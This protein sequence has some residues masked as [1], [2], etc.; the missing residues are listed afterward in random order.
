M[1]PTADGAELRRVHLVHQSFGDYVSGLVGGL[2]DIGLE[3]TVTTVLSGQARLSAP[4]LPGSVTHRT[5]TL[6][7]F[8]D[9]RS[10][11]RAMAE[12]RRA[13]AVPTDVVHWQAVGNPWVDAAFLVQSSRRPVVVTV[14][15]MQPHPG[16]GTVLPGTFAAMQRVAA[17]ADRVTVHAP[18]VR[19]QGVAIG[20]DRDRIS[21]I[22]HGE[23]ASIYRP[24]DELPFSPSTEPSVLFFGRVQG[25]KGLDVL[26]EAMALLDAEGAQARLIVAGSG[27]TLDRLLPEG[28]PTPDWCTV[29]RGHIPR[30]DVP[31]LFERAAVVALPYHEASQSGVA[32]LA[33]GFGRPVVATRTPGLADIV[34]EGRTGL[35]IPTGDAPALADAIGRITADP[36]LAATLCRGAWD[37]ARGE[38][39]WSTIAGR[40][41]DVYRQAAD[42]HRNGG[43]PGLLARTLTAGRRS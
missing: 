11:L 30:K 33:A 15:D 34:E 6:P 35:L 24:V 39:S 2:V 41:L 7:R 5:V 40:L 22:H 9:P 3:V 42:D 10:P 12:I 19:D 25:Y 16:D 36:D 28:R 23:L 18:H 4:S 20:I 38:L 29:L 27:A 32:A 43:G 31:G 8:R 13:L 21:V 1:P 17:R 26:L 14:H 37:H